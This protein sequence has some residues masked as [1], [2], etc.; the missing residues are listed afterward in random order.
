MRGQ[1]LADSYDCLLTQDDYA[2]IRGCSTRTIERER[3]SGAGCPYV[4]C[5]RLVR[6]RRGDILNFIEAHLRRST[7][8]LSPIGTIELLA[9]S[10]APTTP[11]PRPSSRNRS[12]KLP[13]S[14]DGVRP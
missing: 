1:M 5:G 4:K 13:P 2:Q 14:S 11:Q 8:E 3:G 10:R 7:S 6:Y 12:R 9:A